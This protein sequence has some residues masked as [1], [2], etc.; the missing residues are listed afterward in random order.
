MLLKSGDASRVH[1]GKMQSGAGPEKCKDK[2][3]THTICK[4]MPEPVGSPAVLYVTG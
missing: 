1:A 3:A 4:G 2:N